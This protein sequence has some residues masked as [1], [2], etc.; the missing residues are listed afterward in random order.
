MKRCAWCTFHT[1]LTPRTSRSHGVGSG[2]VAVGSVRPCVTIAPRVILASQSC[3][4]SSMTLPR[5]LDGKTQYVALVQSAAVVVLGVSAASRPLRL[6]NG[7]ILTA[8]YNIHV[9]PPCHQLCCCRHY[10]SLTVSRR[11]TTTCSTLS[12]LVCGKWKASA[13]L[14]CMRCATSSCPSDDSKG[15][16]RVVASNA[17]THTTACVIVTSILRILVCTSV[18]T[19]WWYSRRATPISREMIYRTMRP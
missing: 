1:L 5:N 15:S 13:G 7:S 3:R 11:S 8:R 19:T 14:Q 12:A 9:F 16:K 18:V 2:A 17:S 4:P 10:R 6:Q